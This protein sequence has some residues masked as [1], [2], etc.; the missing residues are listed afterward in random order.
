[1]ASASRRRPWRIV[2]VLAVF[3]SSLAVGPAAQSIDPGLGRAIFDA[4]KG[5]DARDVI[6]RVAGGAVAMQGGAVA[7]A[8]C[9]G[10]RGAGGGE[11]WIDAPDIRW[12]ALS[13]PYGARRPGGSARPPYDRASF[14]RAL[15]SGIAPDGVSLD[16]SMPR[17]DLA[18][19]EIDSLHS[20]LMGLSDESYRDGERPAL[21]VLMPKSSTPAADRLLR[22]LQTCPTASATAVDA[23]RT[24]P[25]LRVLRYGSP[26]EI[27]ERLAEMASVGSAAALFAPYLI[28]AEDD[29]SRPGTGLELPVLLPMTMRDLAIDGRIL[30]SLPGL[31]AQ[32]Q[33]LIAPPADAV[34]NRLAIAI[35]ATVPGRDAL[36]TRLRIVAERLGWRATI[37]DSV[38]SAVD[39]NAQNAVLALAD[40]GFPPDTPQRQLQLWVPAAFV[41]PSQLT[42]WA[43]GGVE[44]RIALPYSPTVGDDPRWI[45]PADVWVAAGCELIARLPPLPQRRE[46]VETWRASLAAQPELRLGDWIRVPPVATDDDA[47]SRVFTTDWPPASP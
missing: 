31:R 16:P 14:A 13:K 10:V 19:D 21:I 8:N 15:R 32:A 47:A 23:Q 7:C 6:G 27:D 11:G 5:R 33:A 45:P 35:D 38:A 44:V 28:G 37:H 12:F 39:S 30:F 22:G 2:V 29:F 40:P 46:E 24:L 20:H 3:A 4:G 18:D 9:H 17:F 36:A 42:A 34:A 25:A 41:A 43:A 26:M 1:M